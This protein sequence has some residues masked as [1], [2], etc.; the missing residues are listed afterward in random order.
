VNVQQLRKSR[1]LA[2]NCGVI[3]C[4]DRNDSSPF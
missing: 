2:T 3:G 1:L 4:A